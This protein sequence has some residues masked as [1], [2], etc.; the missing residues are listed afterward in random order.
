MD[1]SIA[2][3]EISEARESEAGVSKEVKEIHG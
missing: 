3:K 2:G 1:Q